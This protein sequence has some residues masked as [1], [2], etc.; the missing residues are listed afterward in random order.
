M[1]HR[2]VVAKSLCP[3]VWPRVDLGEHSPNKHNAFGTAFGFIETSLHTVDDSHLATSLYHCVVFTVIYCVSFWY[4]ILQTRKPRV[5]FAWQRWLRILF[6]NRCS[7]GVAAWLEN[8]NHGKD[9]V[10]R[11]FFL[12]GGLF[13][14]NCAVCTLQCSYKWCCLTSISSTKIHQVYNIPKKHI[15]YNIYI[16]CIYV[17]LYIVYSQI[18]QRR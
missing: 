17:F 15:L 10:D 13:A 7:E 8:A 14:W 16:Y 4:R 3:G 6:S 12:A 9:T 5:H 18:Q 11:L 1:H 2:R